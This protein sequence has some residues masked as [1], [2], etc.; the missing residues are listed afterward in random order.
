[1]RFPDSVANAARKRIRE[2]NAEIKHSLKVIAEGHADQA[3]PDPA[4]KTAVWK[5]RAPFM[6]RPG[7]R[8]AKAAGPEKVW[9]DTTDFVGVSFLER[10]AIAARAVCR[11]T[12]PGGSGTGFLVS[13]RVLITNNHVIG[14]IAE[15]RETIAEFDFERDTQGRSKQPTKFSID[16]GQLFV[17]NDRD[18]L[19][20]TVVAI[21]AKIEGER[22]LGNFGFLPLS[23]ARDKHM[24]GDFVNIVQ[25]PDGREKEVV[26]RENQLVGRP[27]GGIVLHYVAD[28]EPGS[29]GSPVCNVL[30]QV[31]A[32]HHWGGPHRTL[33][34]VR[35]QRVPETVNEGI[36]ISAIYLDLRTQRSTLPNPAVP[37]LDEVLSASLTPSPLERGLPLPDVAQQGGASWNHTVN[38]DGVATW[39][40]PLRVSVQLGLGAKG[41]AQ[42]GNDPPLALQTA[43]QA[44]RSERKML[45]DTDY[46][47]RK[48]Y[49]PDF[50]NDLR[51][52]LPKLSA[53]MRKLAAKLIDAPNEVELKYQHFSIVMNAKRKLAFFTATNIDGSTAKDVDRDQF[54]FVVTDPFEGDDDDEAAEGTEVWALDDRIAPEDQTPSDFYS[55]QQTYD[56]AGNPINDRRSPAHSNRM[57]QQGHLTR[58]QDPLWGNDPDIVLRAHSD[59]FHVTNRAP[60]VGF[61]NMGIKK[62]GAESKKKKPG[63]QFYWRALED[64]VLNNAR[65]DRQRVTVFTGPV[66]DEENDFLWPRDGYEMEDFK[67]PREFWKLVLRVHDGRLKATALIADQSPLIDK[68]PGFLEMNR[69]EINR[70]SFEKVER[71]H[72]SISFLEQKTGLAFPAAVRAADTFTGN[73]ERKAIA[74]LESLLGDRK[75]RKS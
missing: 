8:D 43:P 68:V 38:S 71:Y 23:A 4:R 47:T 58:R 28:T 35:G 33:F 70:V 11:L 67:A 65:A 62:P 1:M 6:R 36:R 41:P 55:G 12:G 22:E 44:D 69:A 30:W 9:G 21:G 51:V 74:S 59:T 27:K 17:T 48:G 46:Q 13:P 45:T 52:P 49:D 3:E 56:A 26:L 63:G 16:P 64:Y 61:F 10:G 7:R 20:Y 60:Q 66:F 54:P 75:R 39:D 53:K 5:C 34:D 40:I 50:L 32:L 15:A 2:S 24:L 72:V 57:F 73:G 29:S 25:H 14:S 42:K 18:N 37:L 19:D 31:V